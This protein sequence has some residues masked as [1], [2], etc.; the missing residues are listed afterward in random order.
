MKTKTKPQLITCKCGNEFR[1]VY[2][3]LTGIIKSKECPQCQYKKLYDKATQKLGVNASKK[4]KCEHQ[5]N[6]MKARKAKRVKTKK[7]TVRKSRTIDSRIDEAWSKLVKL[8]AGNKCEVCG[9]ISTLNSHHIYSRAKKSVR[10][11]LDNGICLCV[12]H[13][14]GNSFSAHKTSVEFTEWLYEYKGKEFME[15]LRIRSHNTGKFS[16]FEKKIILSEMNKEI[17]ELQKLKKSA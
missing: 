17:K 4:N 11:D 15:N 1:P 12:N 13:H 16:H 10:W 14:I 5:E 8:R 9:K 6:R 3:Y 2:D 7:Q